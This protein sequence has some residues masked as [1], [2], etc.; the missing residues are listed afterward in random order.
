M[1]NLDVEDKIIKI[2]YKHLGEVN[3]LRGTISYKLLSIYKVYQEQFMN[4][5]KINTADNTITMSITPALKESK[6]KLVKAFLDADSLNK[7][8][9]LDEE[10]REVLLTVIENK[11]TEEV[12]KFNSNIES[13]NET[14]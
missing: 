3:I 1:I 6:R 4:G 14:L 8:N 2:E 11:I 9:N 13:D 10:K 5:G 7:V 12:D